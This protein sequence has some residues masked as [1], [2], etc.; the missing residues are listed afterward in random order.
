MKKKALDDYISKGETVKTYLSLV[1]SLTLHYILCLSHCLWCILLWLQ[2][3]YDCGTVS[4]VDRGT[5]RGEVSRYFRGVVSNFRQS[6][7]DGVNEGG[8]QRQTHAGQ[9]D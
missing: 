4:L 9:E 2:G 6:D 3:R 1:Y 7:Q 8:S 5:S